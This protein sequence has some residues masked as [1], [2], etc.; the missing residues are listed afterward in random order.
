[1]VAWIGAP[2]LVSKYGVGTV[3]AAQAIASWPD[4]EDIFR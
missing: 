4:L 3:S 2:T 1:M